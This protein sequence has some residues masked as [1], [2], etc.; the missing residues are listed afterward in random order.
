MLANPDKSVMAELSLPCAELAS[1]AITSR[2]E[3]F[4]VPL[5]PIITHSGRRG[6]LTSSSRRNPWIRSSLNR[7]VEWGEES[8]ICTVSLL[9]SLS[10][11][12]FGRPA[13]GVHEHG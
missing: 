6:I 11:S 10:L 9:S 12:F 5:A 4:P 13:L 7:D 2:T 1:S 8:L 3:V